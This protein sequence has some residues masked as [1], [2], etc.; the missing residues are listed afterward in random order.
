MPE[1]QPIYSP[2]YEG[3]TYQY[4]FAYIGEATPEE[5]E[6]AD[7]PYAFPSLDEQRRRI[8][9]TALREHV[10]V[11]EEFIDTYREDPLYERPALLELLTAWG[12]RPPTRL[13]LGDERVLK[14]RSGEHFQ[15]QADLGRGRLW[16]PITV[17]ED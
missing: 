11:V 2:Y 4:G 6:Y 14:E 15:L 16:D 10:I 7:G 9:E 5:Q 1:H 13:Y 8:A 3:T 17:A 12:N